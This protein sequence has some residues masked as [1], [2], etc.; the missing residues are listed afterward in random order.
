MES[1]Y[2]HTPQSSPLRRLVVELLYLSGLSPSK[3]IKFNSHFYH[4]QACQDI[5]SV[6]SAFKH[7]NLNL[8]DAP[9]YSNPCN[10]QEHGNRFSVFAARQNTVWDIQKEYQ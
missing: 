8:T 10:Y 7:K 5:S 3:A 6:A 1:V 2:Q 4:K 9:F